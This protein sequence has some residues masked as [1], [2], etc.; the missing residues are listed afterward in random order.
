MLSI[1][2][3]N[4][5][6]A[7]PIIETEDSDVWIWSEDGPTRA[8]VFGKNR[9]I[10]PVVKLQF[11]F[12]AVEIPKSK[13]VSLVFQAADM[14]VEEFHRVKKR[15]IAGVLAAL[16]DAANYAGD[17]RILERG[18]VF[19]N[20]PI[21]SVELAI[22]LL[23]FDCEWDPTMREGL[24]YPSAKGVLSEMKNL[25][26]AREIRRSMSIFEVMDS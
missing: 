16:L 6:D 7:L 26:L 9:V 5:G 1:I 15:K 8:R 17:F 11:E 21:G 18:S 12:K 25:D 22:F 20:G 3:E 4:L 19:S 23:S 2:W 10:A 14:T 13:D 24:D